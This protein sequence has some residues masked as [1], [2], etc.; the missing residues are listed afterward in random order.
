[1]ARRAARASSALIAALAL[2]GCSLEE[3][4]PPEIPPPDP[5]TDVRQAHRVRNA[6][7][8]YLREE[9]LIREEARSCSEGLPPA[10]FEQVCGPDVNPL[11]DQQRFHLR[12]NLEGLVPRVGLRCATALRRV[13]ALPARRAGDAL[14]AAA[15]ACEREYRAGIAG[16]R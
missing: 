13:L 15:D 16:D 7:T 9:R 6:A 3:E 1:M 10:L 11:V 5:P 14:S 8:V 4:R 2:A 12:E